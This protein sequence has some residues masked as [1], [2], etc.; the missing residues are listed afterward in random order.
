MTQ[1]NPTAKPTLPSN[2]DSAFPIPAYRMPVAR[3]ALIVRA[4]GVIAYPTEAVFGL[5]CLPQDELACERIIALK[6]R[7]RQKGMLLIAADLVQVQ[8]FAEI[9]SGAIAEKILSSWPGPVSWILKARPTVPAWITGGRDTVGVRLTAH[10]LARA[11]CA[12]SG[13]AIV[14]TS[15]NTAGR[16]PIRRIAVLR[17]QF[18]HEV[19]MILPGSLGGLLTPSRIYNASNGHLIRA[20]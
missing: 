1:R 17:R 13:S 18:R 19:D 10:P 5:G 8:E 9:P 6:G 16:T 12:Q 2:L 20:D 15:A 3:A 7:A 11:L 4:G 14:S